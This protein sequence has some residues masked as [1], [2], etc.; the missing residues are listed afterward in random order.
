MATEVESVEGDITAEMR[1]AEIAERL[2]FV[3]SRKMNW[4]EFKAKIEGS[5]VTDADPI[6][7]IEVHAPD[8]D[9]PLKVVLDKRRSN[10]RGIQVTMEY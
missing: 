6:F 10:L 8:A 7:M 5:G 4:G 2:L 9:E 1:A 3:P